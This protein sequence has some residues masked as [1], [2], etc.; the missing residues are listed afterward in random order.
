MQGNVPVRGGS[1]K[2]LQSWEW[3]APETVQL[4]KLRE[5]LRGPIV[6]SGLQ[7]AEHLVDARRQFPRIGRMNRPLP[8]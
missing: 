6:H 5:L 3:A 2:I 4:E 1:I 8:L 7:I